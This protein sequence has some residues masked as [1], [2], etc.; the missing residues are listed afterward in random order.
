MFDTWKHGR[1]WRTRT[2]R[3]SERARRIEDLEAAHDL[4]ARKLIQAGHEAEALRLQVLQD[5]EAFAELAQRVREAD[6]LPGAARERVDR[7]ASHRGRRESAGARSDRQIQGI[8]ILADDR[9]SAR[10]R[11]SCPR[12]ARY[13]CQE[14]AEERRP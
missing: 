9:S 2:S 3:F 10:R 4:V 6:R 13:S 12:L 5:S 14:G 8:A 1:N 7:G 11:G